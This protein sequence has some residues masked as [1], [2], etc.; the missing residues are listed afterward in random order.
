MMELSELLTAGVR[1]GLQHLYG[2]DA[3]EV[4]ITLQSTRKEFEG[5]FTVVTFPLTPP[6]PQEARGDRQ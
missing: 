3:S 5:E 4:D 2:T 1:D 6:R